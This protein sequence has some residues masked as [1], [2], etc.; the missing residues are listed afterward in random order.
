MD[1]AKEFVANLGDLATFD[2]EDAV[3]ITERVTARDAQIARA[4]A[5]EMRNR[6]AVEAYKAYKAGNGPMQA[7]AAAAAAAANNIRALSLICPTC[8]GRGAIRWKEPHMECSKPCPDCHALPIP[9]AGDWRGITEMMTTGACKECD[10]MF[11]HKTKCPVN[12]SSHRE[13]SI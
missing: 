13:S 1:S 10:G 9:A 11:Q 7:M 8:E 6:C 5:E 12:H 4:A 2:T 3:R